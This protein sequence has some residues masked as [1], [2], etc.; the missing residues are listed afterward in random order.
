MK[1]CIL[2]DSSFII[3]TLKEDDPFH[4][5]ALRIVGTLLQHRQDVKYIIPSIVFFEVLATLIKKGVAK[6]IVENSLWSFLHQDNILSVSIIE[7]MA[8]RLVNRLQS[9]FLSNLKTSDFLIVNIGLDYDA[10]ILTFDKKMRQRVGK[11]YPHIYYCSDR[12]NMKDETKRFLADLEHSI[13]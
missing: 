7:T 8:F 12:G 2:Q 1:P 11:A 6:K 4:Y 10:Q 5:D 9:K 13:T 3:A